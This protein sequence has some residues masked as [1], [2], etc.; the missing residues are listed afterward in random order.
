MGRVICSTRGISSKMQTQARLTSKSIRTCDAGPPFDVRIPH[1]SLLI[2][3]LCAGGYASDKHAFLPLLYGWIGRWMDL[4]GTRLTVCCCHVLFRSSETCT[5]FPT[6]CYECGELLR[7]SDGG[8]HCR[9]TALIIIIVHRRLCNEAQSSS[10]SIRIN[11]PKSELQVCFSFVAIFPP[12]F[13]IPLAV[14]HPP[15]EEA[16]PPMKEVFFFLL[17]HAD[18]TGV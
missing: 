1:S 18:R 2:S 12:Q 7:D 10:L 3:L 15:Q 8:R 14:S 16:V 4:L 6:L 11:K 17:P 9:D 5:I 13:G